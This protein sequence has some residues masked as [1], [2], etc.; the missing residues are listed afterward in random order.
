MNVKHMVMKTPFY[1][2]ALVLIV[3][4]YS[5]KKE[6]QTIYQV[7]NQV[8][9]QNSAQ[10]TNLKTTNQFISIAYNDL[11]N[12][13]VSSTQLN[14]LNTCLEAFGDQA[15]M[16]DIIIKNLLN[17]GGVSIPDSTTMMADIA[18]FVNQTYIRFYNRQPTAEEVWKMQM[19]IQQPGNNINPRMIYYSILTSTE[20]RYY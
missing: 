1:F 16:E 6:T 7:Q 2:I 17:N 20:Y 19:L 10:K 15:T 12:A 14:N 3:L 13:S 9:Y 18:T 8:M 11:Y 4:C 5:C